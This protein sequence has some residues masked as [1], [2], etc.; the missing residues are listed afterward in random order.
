MLAQEHPND[1]IYVINDSPLCYVSGLRA[2]SEYYED[3]I[4]MLD[5]VV[6][7]SIIKGH[8]FMTGTKG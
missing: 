4:L 5:A 8:L 3:D 7:R 2:V 1:T 6:I